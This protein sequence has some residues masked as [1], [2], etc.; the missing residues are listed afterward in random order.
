[1]WLRR[2]DDSGEEFRYELETFFSAPLMFDNCG[3]LEKTQMFVLYKYWKN[4]DG[5]FQL[6]KSDEKV[7]VTI[8]TLLSKFV[9]IDSAVDKTI[10]DLE[11]FKTNIYAKN[12]EDS[13]SPFNL[14]CIVDVSKPSAD[15]A[16]CCPE[17]NNQITNLDNVNN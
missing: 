15:L 10:Q 12:L 14:G 8:E 16:N 7:Y 3:R 2:I 9:A 17:A 5:E 13:L 4:N 6:C 1:M 11:N